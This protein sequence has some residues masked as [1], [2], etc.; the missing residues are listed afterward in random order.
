MSFN[1]EGLST[2]KQLI[3]DLINKHQCDIVCLQETHRGPDNIR[4]HIPGMDLVIEKPHE[5]NNNAV[6][7]KIRTII[8][9]MSLAN[10]NNVEI[11][12]VDL[13]GISVT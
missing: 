4:T 3:A 12:T 9:S 1:V 10:F 8:N 11:L 2:A 7:V 13:N 6:F 5:Q